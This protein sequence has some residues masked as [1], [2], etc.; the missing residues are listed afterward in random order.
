MTKAHL[1]LLRENYENACNAYLL[2]LANMWEWDC[3]GDYGFWIADEV[4]GV[5]SYGDS[6]FID[7]EDIIY[8]VENNISEDAYYEWQEY[9]VWANNFN[10]NVPNLKSWCMGCPRVDKATQEK[11]TAMRN[12]LNELIK[13]TKAKF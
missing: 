13:D 5:Y 12:E 8:C 7:M 2:A 4:G 10:Q 6:L 3:S 11:L 9:C 1:R